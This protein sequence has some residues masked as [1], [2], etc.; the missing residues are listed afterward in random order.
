[1]VKKK[2]VQSVDHT[3]LKTRFLVYFRLSSKC[4]L[5]INLPFYHLMFN[6]D[7]DGDMQSAG[8]RRYTPIAVTDSHRSYAGFE[9]LVQNPP[10]GIVLQ[11]GSDAL[12]VA[13][14][15]VDLV[16]LGVGV[17]LDPD[18]DAVIGGERLLQTHT[19]PQAKDGGERAV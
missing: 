11:G 8:L 7:P 14:L 16:I 19:N 4:R 15:F 10:E 18:V 17:L 13:Q 12:L 1:M 2:K 5:W 9:H 3:Y 6:L